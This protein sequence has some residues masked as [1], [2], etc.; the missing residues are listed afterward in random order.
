MCIKDCETESTECCF[1]ER[2]TEWRACYWNAAATERLFDVSTLETSSIRNRWPCQ[3]MSIPSPVLCLITFELLHLLMMVHS[4]N[5]GNGGGGVPCLC[6]YFSPGQLM[7]MPVERPSSSLMFFRLF[8]ASSTVLRGANTD[9]YVKYCFQRLSCAYMYINTCNPT[10]KNPG[11]LPRSALRWSRGWGRRS[12]GGSPGG[13]REWERTGSS[14]ALLLVLWGV[15]AQSGAAGCFWWWCSW[16]PPKDFTAS[17]KTSRGIIYSS[18][19]LN[20][21]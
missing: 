19:Q 7:R 6:A 8:S 11:R 21:C 1:S 17:N 14:G 10:L 15:N 3:C 12:W 16:G 2:K 13:C 5:F 9:S 4:S 20:L 18:D